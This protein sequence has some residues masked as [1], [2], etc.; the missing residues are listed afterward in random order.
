MTF[1]P[2]YE[3]PKERARPA[4]RNEHEGG[5]CNCRPF[6]P[7]GRFYSAGTE[8]KWEACAKC[9]LLPRRVR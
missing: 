5:E 4:D 7:S 8:I 6:L 1:K 2:K 9:G 3:F